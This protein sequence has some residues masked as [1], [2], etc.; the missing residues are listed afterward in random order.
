MFACSP[1]LR[2][3]FPWFAIQV[4]FR[5]EKAVSEALR[6]KGLSEF[7]PLYVSRHKAS[8]G[9]E[10]VELP[11]FPTYVFCR[12][13]PLNRLPVLVTPGVFSIVGARKIPTSIDEEEI[14]AIRA[15]TQSGLRTEPWPFLNIGERVRVEEGPLR[16]TSGILQRVKNRNCLIISIML[17]QRSVAVEIE[18]SWVQSSPMPWIRRC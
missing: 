17:L 5:H 16:G 3:V 1:A 4:K 10:D 14:S 13:D 11:L 15:A 2:A 6:Q 12:F 7:L 8:R 9:F 18:P